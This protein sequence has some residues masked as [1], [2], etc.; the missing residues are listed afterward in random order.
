MGTTLVRNITC[1]VCFFYEISCT[2]LNTTLFLTAA[3]FVKQI[4]M[5]PASVNSVRSWGR[6]IQFTGVAGP[7]TKKDYAGEDQQKITGPEQNRSCD[8]TKYNSEL[9]LLSSSCCVL[10]WGFFG[11]QHSKFSNEQTNSILLC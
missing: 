2:Y 7:E 4:N 5:N 10:Q 3:E 6:K 1:I 8:I 11:R 9:S